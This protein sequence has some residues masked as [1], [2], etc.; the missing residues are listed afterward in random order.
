MSRTLTPLRPSPARLGRYSSSGGH[1]NGRGH[2][3]TVT[4]RTRTILEPVLEGIALADE[5]AEF[6]RRVEVRALDW[7]PPL[8]HEAIRWQAKCTA[9]RAELHDLARLLR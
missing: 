2:P 1:S 8:Y 9:Y 7:D 5:G 3:L 6:G 4:V